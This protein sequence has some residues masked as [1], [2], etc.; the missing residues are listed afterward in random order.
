MSYLPSNVLSRLRF[1]II[2]TGNLSIANKTS[3]QF[4]NLS[5]LNF[6][7]ILWSTIIWFEPCLP[8]IFSNMSKWSLRRFHLWG[9]EEKRRRL[10]A[11]LTRRVQGSHGEGYV[12]WLKGRSHPVVAGTSS[13]LCEREEKVIKSF[14]YNIICWNNPQITCTWWNLDLVTYIT[15][16]YIAALSKSLAKGQRF[17]TNNVYIT[18][19]LC[20]SEGHSLLCGT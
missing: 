4:H 10:C 18:I 6:L 3:L 1:C 20:G 11:L 17:P 8:K 15:H 13:H 7:G 12:L 14:D 19:T 5:P 2:F 9:I 16:I